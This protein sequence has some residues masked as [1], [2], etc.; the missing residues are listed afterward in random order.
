MVIATGFDE[1]KV[2]QMSAAATPLLRQL[3]S[4]KKQQDTSKSENP[5]R[6]G[7]DDAVIKLS[8]TQ[9]NEEELEVPTFMRKKIGGNK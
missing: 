6:G 9:L 3:P 7:N 1:R 4:Y 2:D 5:A 8:G